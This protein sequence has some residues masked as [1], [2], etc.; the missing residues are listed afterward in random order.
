MDMFYIYIYMC[1]CV[2]ICLSKLRLVIFIEVK[3]RMEWFGVIWSVWGSH[4]PYIFPIQVGAG[5]GAKLPSRPFQFQ[6]PH[7]AE[8]TWPCCAVTITA[9]PTS[10]ASTSAAVGSQGVPAKLRSTTGSELIPG[11]L[12]RA[13]LGL[14]FFLTGII[15][16]FTF[17]I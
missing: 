4:V 16:V 17:S 6:A 5:H 11:L 3:V 1:V 14:R 2:L 8:A 7:V 10:P 12:G 9:H 13:I 15:W